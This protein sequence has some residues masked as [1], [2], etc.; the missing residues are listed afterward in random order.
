MFVERD[1]GARGYFQVPLA[2]AY[3]IFTQAYRRLTGLARTIRGPCMSC[4]PGKI[5]VEGI[6]EIDGEKLF[7]LKFLQ[8]RN[9][10]WVNRIF[11]AAYDPRASW[12][13][14]LQP[15]FGEKRFFFETE[16]SEM[17]RSGHARTWLSNPAD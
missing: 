13:D 2:R 16:M 4:L 8:A 3:E 6:T 1:T 10:D 17:K 11:F 7:V 14:E 15:A 12:I 9:P 5:L